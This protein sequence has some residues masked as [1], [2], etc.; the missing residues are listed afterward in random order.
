VFCR[1][2]LTCSLLVV[3]IV[4]STAL[5]Q[6]VTGTPPFASFGGGPFDVI[7]LGNLNVHFSIPVFSKAGRG[8]P[9]NYALSY[10]SSVWYPVGSSGN[11]SWSAVSNW[12][13][14]GQGAAALGSVSYSTGVIYCYIYDHGQK[15][16]DGERDTY[17]NWIYVDRIGTAH[18]FAVTTW[19]TDGTITPCTGGSPNATAQASDGSGYTLQLTYG[20]SA[21]I[22]SPDGTLIS[23]PTSCS[24][25]TDRNGNQIT[26]SSGSFTDTLNTT[27]LTITGTA[28]NPVTMSYTPPAGGSAPVKIAYK[29]YTV[30]TNFGA[31][32]IGES[33]RRSASLVDSIT[34]P[35]TTAY[36]FTYEQT[37][38]TP[39]SGA[40]TPLSGTY[41][42]YCVTARIA[43]VT[44]PTGGSISYAYS[45]GSN[46]IN[47]DG[48]TATLTRTVSDGNTGN[49]WTY[50]HSLPN[51]VSNTSVTDPLGNVNYMSFAGI[52]EV[53]REISQKVNGTPTTIASVYTCYNV[54]GTPVWNTCSATVTPPF[55]RRTIFAQFPDHTGK[56][57]ETDENYDTYGKLTERDSYDFGTLGSGGPGGILRKE[58][59][60]YSLL[61]QTVSGTTQSFEVLSSDTITNGANT[62][63][64]KTTYGYDNASSIAATSSIPHHVGITGSHGLL[65]S[66]TSN[67]TSSTTLQ[68][69]YKYYD[70]GV[71]QS[72]A[73]VNGAIT[74]YGYGATYGSAGSCNGAFKTSVTLPLSLPRS[75]AWNCTGGVMTSATDE[76]GKITRENFTTDQHFWRPES[77]QDPLSNTMSFSY[78]TTQAESAFNFNNNASTVDMLRTLD[79]LGR[80]IYGQRKQGYTSSN[81]DSVQYAYDALGRR[82][83][84]SMPYV[85]SAGQAPT[86]PV[87]ST[88]TY[89]PLNRPTQVVDA[90]GGTTKLTY[91]QNDAYQEVSPNPPSENTKRKQLEY[92][93]L[94]RLTSV[95]EITAG[96]TSWPGGTCSQTNPYTGYWTKYQYN[97]LGQITSVT[98]N[99]QSTSSTQGR[100]YAY[101]QLGRLTSENNPENGTTT[102]SY[103]PYSFCWGSGADGNLHTRTDN[104][105]HVTCYLHDAL[106]RLTDTAGWAN[107]T[108]QGP[109]RRFRYDA[110]TNGV[111]SPGTGW[112]LTNLAGRPVEV[113]TDSCTPWPPTPITDE[114]F[115]YSPRGE[116]TDV[117]ES[118]P[119]SGGYYHSTAS[120]W[121]HGGLNTLGL[122]NSSSTSLLPTQT[123][124]VDG[125]GRPSSVTAASGQ[126]PVSSVTYATTGTTQPIGSLTQVT[127]GSGDFDNFSYDTNTGRIKGYQFNVGSSGQADI[128]TL[129]WNQ[130]GTLQKLSVTD[131]LSASDTQTCNY[132]YD[133]LARIGSVNCANGSTPRWNQTFGFDT[134]GNISKTVPVG[135]TGTSF[136]PTYSSATNRFSTI[137]GVTPTYDS[138]GDVTADG[139]H[140]YGWDADGNSISV[141]NVSVTY[142]ALDR[143]VEQNRSGTYVQSLYSPSGAKVAL[144]LGQSLGEARIALPGGSW[145]MYTPSGLATYWHSDWL[146][147]SRLATTP[148]RT[149]TVDTGFGPYG[150][151]YGQSG[152]FD[153]TFTGSSFV[154]TAPGLYDFLYREYNPIQGRWASPDPA[155][156]TAVNLMNP[157]TWNRYAYVAN[158]PLNNVDPLG[159]KCLIDD[160]VELCAGNGFSFGDTWN[161][162]NL[163][164]I[165]LVVLVPGREFGLEPF[166][167]GNGFD[168]F[169][170]LA[171]AANNGTTPSTGC[172]VS[173]S[174]GPTANTHGFSHC[175]VT[176]NQNGKYTTYDGGPTGSIWNSTLQV[177]AGPSGPP[178]PNT[179]YITDSCSMAG[180]VPRVAQQINDANMWY[181]F[182]FQNSNTAAGMMLNQCGANVSLPVWGPQ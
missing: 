85:A 52:Y 8:M 7:T 72:A 26:F 176:V 29:T 41:A 117:Y 36:V 31:S 79:G 3:L 157:Q 152:Q 84:V 172:S 73:D 147:S 133:D 88:T 20:N 76:N 154:D 38:S 98:Q 57:S 93:G 62:Q 35:D 175:S 2:K 135:G 65:T 15:L 140:T 108:W 166:V 37:P 54:T 182:P 42:N 97:P 23:C 48:S 127:F 61:S 159:L 66:I 167:I 138:N 46:G 101:D 49:Q 118:T 16:L 120:Y 143:V 136:L 17:S 18:K 125:E 115:G 137:P 150:E 50:A 9:F 25:A 151:T 158:A 86:S 92:D 87:L 113:E 161:L 102:Y 60:A 53:S 91:S 1:H 90:G 100:S 130:N 80:Q 106:H 30:A 121:A 55:S 105:G 169:G 95:C 77:V 131:A 68:S 71:L 33:A 129:T 21:T 111:I 110:S 11:Q 74:T 163:F 32:G 27:A 170:N 123:Y 14:Q 43:S 44:L 78:G 144:M 39:V 149:V 10:D 67:V 75:Y 59:L 174:C 132:G 96:T 81:F 13:W 122:L 28:P 103:D 5:S 94:G 109:C 153:L 107:N 124:R 104:A 119:H 82:S 162:F 171:S 63:Y 47:S 40:C 177:Q 145:A 156:V 141:D 178:G 83:Q 112:N 142:D 58:L 70:T 160:K 128:G 4:A 180:C 12:G 179:F 6:M 114:W 134:F 146:G 64:A 99:A 24:S 116:L 56:E 34:L 165:P 181:S 22:T 173:G 139:L 69:S 168:V 51:G 89:D 45:G 19:V 155:G 164:N 148:S 126:N